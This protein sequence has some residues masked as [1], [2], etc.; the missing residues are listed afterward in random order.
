MKKPKA[1]TTITYDPT[2]WQLVPREPTVGV[3][4][5]TGAGAE[6]LPSVDGVFGRAGKLSRGVY[7]AMLAAAPQ[8]PA[9]E[10]P[11]PLREILDQFQWFWVW[12]NRSV[13]SDGCDWYRYSASH[14]S[15]SNYLDCPAIGIL[16]P[17]RLASTLS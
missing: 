5:M 10:E 12:C 6:C 4:E 16:K 8:P 17:P 2:L 9:C 14:V 15:L 1:D 7:K 11:R 3:N 13:E